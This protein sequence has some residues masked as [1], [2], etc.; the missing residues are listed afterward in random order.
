MISKEK[1]LVKKP[2]IKTKTGVSGRQTTTHRTHLRDVTASTM[3]RLCFFYQSRVSRKESD[4][5]RARAAELRAFKRR[6]LNV[7]EY[8]TQDIKRTLRGKRPVQ[9]RLFNVHFLIKSATY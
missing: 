2:N 1:T 4:I 7:L 9:H 6:K 8:I 5:T 3:S